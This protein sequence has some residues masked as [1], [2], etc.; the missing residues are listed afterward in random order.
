MKQDL[1]RYTSDPLWPIVVETVHA[2]VMFKNH[3][4][5]VADSL[6]PEKPEISPE[7]LAVELGIPLGEALVILFELQQERSGQQRPSA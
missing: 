4:R 7:E 3:K 5:Y 6:L 1:S 2:L